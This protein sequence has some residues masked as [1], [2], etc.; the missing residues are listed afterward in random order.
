MKSTKLIVM[1][2]IATLTRFIEKMHEYGEEEVAR[3][4][5][6]SEKVPRSTIMVVEMIRRRYGC[7]FEKE[8]LK[9]NKEIFK[10]LNE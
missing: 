9:L 2:R 8:T 6:T 1:D 4:L 3:V 10:A 5:S 7:F